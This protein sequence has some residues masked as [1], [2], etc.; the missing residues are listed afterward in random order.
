MAE[1]A[2][3]QMIRMKTHQRLP[4]SLFRDLDQAL[5]LWEKAFGKAVILNLEDPTQQQQHITCQFFCHPSL[6]SVLPERACQ[7]CMTRHPPPTKGSPPPMRP[8]SVPN[9]NAAKYDALLVQ[10]AQRG[11]IPPTLQRRM[12][13]S[14]YRI[15]FQQK[16]PKWTQM[17]LS[18]PSAIELETMVW[19]PAWALEQKW[20]WERALLGSEQ[21]E[22]ARIAHRFAFDKMVDQKLFCEINVTRVLEGRDSWEQ[23]LEFL[24][25]NRTTKTRI[26]RKILANN[27]NSVS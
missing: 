17:P 15:D 21:V 6:S 18:C 22:A 13:K 12:D 24:K 7:E 25:K 23:V 9:G 5:P 14:R 4:K 11:L 1:T 26:H 16:V 3:Q 19:Q 10:A 8:N 27:S 20:I 2:A